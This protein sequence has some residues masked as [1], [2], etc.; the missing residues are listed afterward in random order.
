[1]DN[2]PLN[3]AKHLKAIAQRLRQKNMRLTQPRQQVLEAFLQSRRLQTPQEIFYNARNQ[4]INVGLTTVYRML[5][6]LSELNL[7]RALLLH[8]EIRYIFCPPE[9]HHHL[10]CNNCGLVQE[11]FNCPIAQ[12]PTGSFKS[13]SHQLDFYGLCS[14]C[15][16]E[17]TLN[18]SEEASK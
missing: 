5:E 15:Q 13:Q 12:V 6:S 7:A 4:G 16:G 2:T 18:Q 14:R 17:D 11:V 9:H 10:I 3:M 1:M 8:G